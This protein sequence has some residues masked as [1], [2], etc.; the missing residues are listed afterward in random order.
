MIRG[1]VPQY[2]YRIYPA[3]VTV[4]NRPVPYRTVPHYIA[5]D[6]IFKNTI[7]TFFVTFTRHRY[8]DRHI[9]RY[10]LKN[11]SVK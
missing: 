9:K 1:F 7:V 3:S 10:F 4:P 5:W 8:K 6:R 11:N 2:F